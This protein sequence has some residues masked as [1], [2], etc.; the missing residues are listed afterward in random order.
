VAAA[1]YVTL[2]A[3]KA[4]LNI[5][6]STFDADL[7]LAITAASRAI[8]QYGGSGRF[9]YPGPANETRKFLPENSGYCVITDLNE[10]VSL[11][12]STGSSWVLDQDFYLEPLEAA[13][14]GVPYTAIRTI[15]KPFLF[16]KSEISPGGWTGVD[17]RISVT[18]TFGWATTPEP[19]QEAASILA[20]RLFQRVRQAP[21]GIVSLGA[22]AVAFH[23][24]ETD[25]DVV[26]LV[27]PYSRSVLIV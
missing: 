6:E 24:G 14:D 17:G 7:Q 11:S 10:F 21:F 27:E 26:S 12:D 3:L 13:Q 18:G 2:D 16:T 22:E 5:T 23:L 9:F 4:S 15:A 19:I 20:A 1:D 25:P 8:D